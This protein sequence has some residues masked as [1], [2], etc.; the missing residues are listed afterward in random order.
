MKEYTISILCSKQKWKAWDA[1]KSTTEGSRVVP[2]THSSTG[3]NPNRSKAT[4]KERHAVLT[5]GA[6]FNMNTHIFWLVVIY[7]S[8]YLYDYSI[9][10]LQGTKIGFLYF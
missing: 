2:T 5:T 6:Y 4:C 10:T 7:S 1:E 8:A 3:V 9:P